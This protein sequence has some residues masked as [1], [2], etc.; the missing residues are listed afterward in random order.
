MNIKINNDSTKPVVKLLTKDEL[1][2]GRFYRSNN[3]TNLGYITQSREQDIVFF[4]DNNIVFYLNERAKEVGLASKN[5][6]RSYY[7]V[8]D[9]SV[10]LTSR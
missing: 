6:G 8:F 1:R 9:T 10:T 3:E 5:L 4:V 2:E 7:E